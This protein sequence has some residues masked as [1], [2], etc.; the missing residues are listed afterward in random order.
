MLNL[1][2]FTV[3]FNTWAEVNYTSSGR[4]HPIRSLLFKPF[5]KETTNTTFQTDSLTSVLQSKIN[6]LASYVKSFSVMKV[7]LF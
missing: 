4:A 2:C 1:S 5:T 7:V 6:G 3:C